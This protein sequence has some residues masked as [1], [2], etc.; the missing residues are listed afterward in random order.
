MHATGHS[1]LPTCALGDAWP[2]CCPRN[3]LASGYDRWYLTVHR[4]CTF[5]RRITC[6]PCFPPWPSGSRGTRCCAPSAHKLARHAMRSP[7]P[8]LTPDSNP[9]RHSEEPRDTCTALHCI[10]PVKSLG[11]LVR[12]I[13]ARDR[14][15][16]SHY[17]GGRGPK[18]AM[19]AAPRGSYLLSFYMLRSCQLMLDGFWLCTTSGT[20]G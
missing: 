8:L 15:D 19:H 6:N 10:A 14:V 13:S 12:K 16:V 9:R 17:L 3:S 5:R 18:H 2:C 1:D 11:R 4:Y 7:P 20:S